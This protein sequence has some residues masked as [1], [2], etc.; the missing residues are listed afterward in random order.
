[1]AQNACNFKLQRFVIR[2][3]QHVK[4]H[5][6]EYC[7]LLHFTACLNSH[8]FRALFLIFLTHTHTHA[9][10]HAHRSRERIVLCRWFIP[11]NPCLLQGRR[12]VVQII[13]KCDAH[14]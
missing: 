2:D 4:M 9:P 5:C 13:Q 14:T 1:M 6:R 8:C 11:H 10:T 12:H 7:A 3:D